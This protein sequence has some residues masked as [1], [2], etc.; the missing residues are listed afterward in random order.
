MTKRPLPPGQNVYG[1]WPVEHYGRIPTFKAE[2][3]CLR[4]AGS[5]ASGQEARISL[6]EFVGMPHVEVTTDLH[7][8]RGWSVQNVR[9][10]G[11]PVAHLLDAYP[12]APGVTHVLA[13]AEHGYTSTLRLIDLRH[14]ESLLVDTLDGEPLPPERG[15]PLRLVVP[16]L[17]AYKGPKWL[18]GLEYRSEATRGFWEERGWH[19]VGDPWEEQR[20]SYQE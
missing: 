7:C 4:I 5:T 10:G 16:H 1:H 2:N 14:P 6:E 17:Y 19:I 15:F 18:R 12:P 11:V 13:W 20:Y 8:G 3:W 9:W